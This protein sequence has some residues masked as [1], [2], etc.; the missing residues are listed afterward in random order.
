MGKNLTSIHEDVGSIP[1]LTQWVRDPALPQLQCTS[2]MQLRSGIAVAVAVAGSCHSDVT[3][4]L[5]ISICLRCGPKNI[6]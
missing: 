6:F 4:G 2:Q 5:E 3:P 1:A